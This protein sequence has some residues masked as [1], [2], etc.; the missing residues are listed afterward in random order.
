MTDA[1]RRRAR[2]RTTGSAHLRA[3]ADA[4]RD[5]RAPNPARLEPLRASVPEALRLGPDAARRLRVLHHPRATRDRARDRRLPERHHDHDV[6]LGLH[7]RPDRHR[8]RRRDRDDRHAAHPAERLVGDPVRHPPRP[9]HPLHAPRPVVLRRPPGGR[10][11]GAP[12]GRPQ[13]RPDARRRR[14]VHGN[15][16][17][18]GARVHPG[19]DVHAGRRA[20]VPHPRDRPLHHADLLRPPADHP[21]EVREGPGA[22]LRCLGDGPGELLRHPSGQGLRDRA[23]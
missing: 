10:P 1:T 8:R 14:R 18:P 9:V 17:Q 4:R 21:P 2:G 13:R 15:E 19:A 11:D 5:P 16:H 22:V 20:G 6:D 23:P 12:H 3:P 7:R